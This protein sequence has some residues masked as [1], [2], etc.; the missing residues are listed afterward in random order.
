MLDAIFKEGFFYLVAFPVAML[1]LASAIYALYWSSRTGQMRELE[2]GAKVIF[3]EEE[4][5]GQ[6]TDQVWH[7]PK[8][9]AKSAKPPKV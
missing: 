5:V 8:P 2:D 3:D 9:A 7:Q 6:A 4:P 1:F